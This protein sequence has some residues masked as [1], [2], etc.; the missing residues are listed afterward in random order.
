V[1]KPSGWTSHDV[2]A[3]ARSI[4]G[5]KQV[6][7]GGTLDPMAT[8]LLILG[9]GQGTRVLEYVSG[10]EKTYEATVTF[11][12]ATNTYDAE[13]TVTLE[14]PWSHIT[15]ASLLAA[16]ESFTGTI[17]QRPPPF[18]A[19]KRAGQALYTFARRGETVEIEPRSVRVHAVELLRFA[20]PFADLRVTCG[21]GT[22]IRSLAHDLG[23]TLG[24]AAHLSA[25][26]RTR[27][28]TITL[29]DAVDWGSAQE[30]GRDALV[31]RLLALDRP[32]WSLPALI[33][34]T[35]HG[36]DVRQ[37][38]AV[39]GAFHAAEICRVYDSAGIFLALLRY[40][41]PRHLWQ[42]LKVFH[43]PPRESDASMAHLC[44]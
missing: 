41:S 6:G 8:G 17:Q 42:P 16:L 35:D 26:R 38:R 39:A 22:Y 28:G 24:S 10:G 18:S 7:H 2:V 29:Q 14:A 5:Q 32:L 21:G 40:D 31:G 44:S 30:G 23:I 20:P 15:E 1:D 12:S 13:G 33:V 27:S 11:G 37:G 3:R 9:L 19:L 43:G 36:S 34:D 4:V 25:L